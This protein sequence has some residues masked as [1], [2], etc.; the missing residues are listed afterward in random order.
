MGA[1]G[2]SA[3]AGQ[4]LARVE[5]GAGAGEG[6]PLAVHALG[7]DADGRE[8]ALARA[9][10]G[11]L[12]AS[13]RAY[14]VLDADAD[15]ADYLVAHEFRKGA[16]DA[17][18]GRFEVV[19][20]EGR[21]LVIRTANASAD[22][23]A[24]GNLGFQS[25]RLPETPLDF[26]L[27]KKRGHGAPRLAGVASNAMVA[28]MIGHVLQTNLY[29]G[30]SE[31]TGVVPAM[32]EGTSSNI[33]TRYQSSGD[34]LRRATALARDRFEAAGL[35]AAYQGWTNGGWTGRNV[36]GTKA[37]RGAAA[38]EI[39][40]VCAHIDDLPT[41]AVAPGADDNAS[42]CVA[43]M[44]A[45]EAMKEY[46]FDRTI[47]F[48]LFSGEEQ[49]LLGSEKYAQAASAAGD[50]IVGA[51]NLD[52]IGWDGNLDRAFNM[53]V[54][55]ATAADRAIAATFTNVAGT[56]GLTNV[57]PAIIEDHVD[58]SDHASFWRFGYPAVCGIEEDEGDFNPYYHTV[59]DTLAR[60]NMAFFT[61]C[62]QA[63]VGTMAHLAGPMSWEDGWQ[64]LDGEWRRLAWLG[65]YVPMGSEGWIWHNQHGFWYPA[66]NGT[67]QD[68][69]FYAQDM[70][71]LWTGS[72]AYPYMF[73]ESDGAWLWYNGATNP[74]WFRN[75]ATGT[76]ESRP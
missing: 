70:G 23:E 7:Q 69:W 4:M 52:M 64:A 37:G 12:E 63:A 74:R 44:A 51:L 42:G 47:R 15:G 18:R 75:M 56:Y 54:R 17:A 32:A 36:V 43:V 38:T 49:G 25:R 24:L 31:L 2:L 45:A 71:W 28:A 30:M 50:N 55:P 72:A 29:V 20:E 10:A 1:M 26:G 59:N 65:D 46:S 6:W 3:G 11:E 41:G 58:W 27:A 40:V 67:P 53:Y 5:T 48:V 13:G 33:P 21:R 60:I 57:A 39:V 61:G 34:P 14:R 9:T 22:I 16:R 73:R 8:Y 35:A 62:A 68:A 66:R 76:W 19:H